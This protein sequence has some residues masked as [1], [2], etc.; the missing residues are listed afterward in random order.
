MTRERLGHYVDRTDA[1]VRRGEESVTCFHCV[2]QDW[3]GV[4]FVC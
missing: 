4:K 1:D 3:E 2:S